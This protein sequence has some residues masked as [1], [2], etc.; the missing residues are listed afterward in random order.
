[1]TLYSEMLHDSI[2][3][4]SENWSLLRGNL[5]RLRLV[6]ATFRHP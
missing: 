6:T 3:K 5:G 1:M 2:R 4:Q